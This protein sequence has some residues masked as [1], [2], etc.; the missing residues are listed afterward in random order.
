MFLEHGVRA[1]RAYALER[2]GR[3]RLLAFALLVC[4]AQAALLPVD[5]WREWL[6]QR[7]E[8]TA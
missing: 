3:P 7:K 4:V 6:R 1:M 2:P 5:L 8:K